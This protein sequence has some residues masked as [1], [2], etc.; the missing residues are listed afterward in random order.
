MFSIPLGPTVAAIIIH[1]FVIIG[2]IFCDLLSIRFDVLR[3]LLTFNIRIMIMH[4][5]I[6]VKTDTDLIAAILII[7][8]I[9]VI[10]VQHCCLLI[11]VFR[12][13]HVC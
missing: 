12:L 1:Q 7:M 10:V 13:I 11:V 9:I 2:D 6:I 3:L 4:L 5:I 8:W